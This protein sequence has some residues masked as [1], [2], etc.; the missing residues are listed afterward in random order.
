[1]TLVDD[2][3]GFFPNSNSSAQAGFRVVVRG[4]NKPPKFAIPANLTA[5]RDGPQ[6]TI[7]GF[8]TNISAG[9]TVEE[10]V[11][12]LSFLPPVVTVVDSLWPPIGLF[13]T[14]SVSGTDGALALKMAAARSGFF[15]V[16]LTLK[17]DGGQAFGGY[18]MSTQSFLLVVL[19]MSQP[20]LRALPTIRIPQSDTSVART[21]PKF[22]S[23][24]LANSTLNIQLALTIDL[25]SNPGELYVCMRRDARCADLLTHSTQ[26]AFQRR[27]PTLLPVLADDRPSP[28]PTHPHTRLF[29]IHTHTHT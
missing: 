24:I 29:L 26:Y 23:L 1:M 16:S 12:R 4:V 2:G 9:A 17:D 21:L 8:A 15:H 25:I 13:D 14:F 27:L 6:I 7:P 3:P 22:Y 5:E 11:Q 10:G 20:E 19:P 18:D 28:Y